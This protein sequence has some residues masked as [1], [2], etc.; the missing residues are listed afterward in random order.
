MK[1]RPFLFVSALALS[2]AGAE[3]PTPSR[4]A[5]R[6]LTSRRMREIGVP[7]ASATDARISL[8]ASFCPRSTSLR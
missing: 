7:S 8:D 1:Y 4:T 2:I 5:R 6:S 3:R